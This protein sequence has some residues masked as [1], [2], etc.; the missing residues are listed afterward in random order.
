MASKVEPT[1]FYDGYYLALGLA[2]GLVNPPLPMKIV[3]L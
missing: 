2:S 1:A 3:S